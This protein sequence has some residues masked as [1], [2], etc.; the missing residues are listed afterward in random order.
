MDDAEI[1][2]GAYDRFDGDEVPLRELGKDG[3]LVVAELFNGPTLAF[4]DLSL[5]VL[6]RLLDFFMRKEVSSSSKGRLASTR[7]VTIK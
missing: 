7:V 5:S 2:N 6:A 3:D 1:M 4:K